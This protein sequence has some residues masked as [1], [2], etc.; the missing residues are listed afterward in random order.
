[1]QPNENDEEHGAN[2][3][4]RFLNVDL[5]SSCCVLPNGAERCR[6]SL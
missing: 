4:Q 6:I 5:A 1:V 2:E 3:V